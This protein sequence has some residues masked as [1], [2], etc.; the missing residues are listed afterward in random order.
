MLLL[1]W[2]YNQVVVQDR[3]SQNVQEINKVLEVDFR[4]LAPMG[5][6]TTVGCLGISNQLDALTSLLFCLFSFD[7]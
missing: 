3:H 1:E 4:P 7:L 5:Q 6:W 2:I